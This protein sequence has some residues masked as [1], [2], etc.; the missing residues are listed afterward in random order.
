MATQ[1]EHKP[2]GHPPMADHQAVPDALSGRR[3]GADDARKPSFNGKLH[4][5][6]GVIS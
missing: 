6:H 1:P 3:R 2:N 4:T 5:K